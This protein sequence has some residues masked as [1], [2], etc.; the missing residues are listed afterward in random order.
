MSFFVPWGG[1]V[2]R[3]LREMSTDNA[4]YGHEAGAFKGSLFAKFASPDEEEIERALRNVNSK[5]GS[6]STRLRRVHH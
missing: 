1:H 6:K 3:I 4:P 5:V 2:G